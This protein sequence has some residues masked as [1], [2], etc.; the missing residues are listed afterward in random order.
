M[1]GWGLID[2]YYLTG[3]T[4]AL[5]AAIDLAEISERILG[6][7]QPGSYRVSTYGVRLEARH[8]LI[9]TRLYEA[10]TDAR[11]NN[12]MNHLGQLFVQSPD[13]DARGS[14]LWEMRGY[15]N[16]VS[17]L[18]FGFLNFAFDR[19][20]HIS[21]NSQIRDR[22]IQMANFVKIYGIDPGTEYTGDIVF[23]HP[24][25]G[26]WFH[27]F[28]DDPNPTIA[29]IDSLV[30]GYRL[31]G[32]TSLLERAKYHW[33][34]GS[35]TTYGHLDERTAGDNEVG[36]FLNDAFLSGD[37]FYVSNGD[38]SYAHLLFHDYAHPTSPD[39]TPPAPPTGL[40]IIK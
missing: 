10:T 40:V 38:L 1:W 26:D 7:R 20:Y 34:R 14:Y 36:R 35:K 29:L 27:L 5:D 16:T 4:D 22:L 15:P 9:T 2:Y 33:H 23:D 18:H 21:G 37:V 28:R 32:D 12:Y 6:W 3:D 30:R 8:L 11:W 19:Y 39:T 17:T 13:W 31:T 24:N 25:P